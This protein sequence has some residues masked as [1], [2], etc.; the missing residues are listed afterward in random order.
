MRCTE[1]MRIIEVLRLHEQFNY[2]LR[3]IENTTM[4]SKTTA[5][6]IIKR[7]EELGLDFESAKSLSEKELKRLLFDEPRGRPSKKIPDFETI[8]LKLVSSKKNLQYIWEECTAH[9]ETNVSYSRFCH[10]YR[11]YKY[12]QGIGVYSPIERTPGEKLYIDWVGDTLN[13][14]I[15]RETGELT[16]AY[17]FITTLGDSSY[18]YCEAFPNMNQF[19]WNAAHVNALQWYGATPKIFTPDNCRTAISRAKIWDPKIN[20]AYLELAQ[21]YRVAIEPARIMRPKDKSTVESGVRWVETWLLEWLRDYGPFNTFNELNKAIRERMLELVERKYT[22]KMRK[23]ESRKSLFEKHDLPEMRPLPARP[24]PVYDFKNGTISNNFHIE[25]DSFN[26][27]VPYTY[28]HQQYELHAYQ[29]TIEIFIGKEQVAIHA[30]RYHGKKYITKENHM[31][32]KDRFYKNLGQKDGFYY[33][34]WASYNGEACRIVIDT[35][36]STFEYEPQGYKSCMGVLVLGKKWGKIALN[37]AC[38][39]AIEL[40]SVSYTTIKR[41]ISE[42]MQSNKTPLYGNECVPLPSDLRT[43]EWESL[44]K[45]GVK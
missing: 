36:L 19:S 4:C 32:E 5:G 24:F 27:S 18:P 8:H 43:K 31:P 28:Y 38:V 39:R 15:D 1:T 2:S 35:I 6:K 33:K 17:F 22:S 10:Y 13:C 11:A 26:Y 44:F 37:D 45:G 20:Q 29:N 9:G 34:R 16:K 25:Y 7:S 40:T 12:S 42:N 21:Y 30:R 41:I 14:V 23:D 3:K